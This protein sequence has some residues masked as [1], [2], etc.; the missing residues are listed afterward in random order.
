MKKIIPATRVIAG[1]I[2]SAIFSALVYSFLVYVE[3]YFLYE[4]YEVQPSGKMKLDE[5]ISNFNETALLTTI[6]AFIGVLFWYAASYFWYRIS[7]WQR[8]DSFWVWLSIWAL[9]VIA[10]FVYGYYY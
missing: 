7:A 5:W 8:T 6:L 1:T 4:N 10:L 9:I 2:V 3:A